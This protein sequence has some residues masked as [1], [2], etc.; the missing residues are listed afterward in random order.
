MFGVD[1][2]LL[3]SRGE[4]LARLRSSFGVWLMGEGGS[5]GWWGGGKRGR[6][7]GGGCRGRRRGSGVRCLRV[8]R[9]RVLRRGR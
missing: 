6:L 5:L 9:E 2:G 4:R 3:L 8:F 7:R 1:N